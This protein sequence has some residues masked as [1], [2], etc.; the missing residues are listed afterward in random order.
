MTRFFYL[1]IRVVA[2]VQQVRSGEQ[3]KFTSDVS[4]IAVLR[5]VETVMPSIPRAC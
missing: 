3:N 2:L 1:L 4:A 5:I